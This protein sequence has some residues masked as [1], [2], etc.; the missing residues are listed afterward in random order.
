[1]APA[2]KV[3]VILRDPGRAVRV[4]H[5][6]PPA[7]P[8]VDRSTRPRTSCAASTASTSRGSSRTSTTVACSSCSTNGACASRTASW[9]ARSSFSVSSRSRSPMSSEFHG[10]RSEPA[11][12]LWPERRSVLVD[13]YRDDV[14][15]LRAAS[16][17]DRRVAL[18][19][20]RMTRLSPATGAARRSRVDGVR[21]VL[22]PADAAS[23]SARPRVPTAWS[24]RRPTSSVSAHPTRARR[25]GSSLLPASP[26][27]PRRGRATTSSASSTRS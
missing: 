22:T 13:A 16:P 19:E 27:R 7:A 2:A 9:R 10:D 17:G 12:E 6:A 26:R 20:L 25:G 15:R 3:I 14:A 8:D 23:T 11:F 18:E 24:P 21:P 1:M 4:G 5:H